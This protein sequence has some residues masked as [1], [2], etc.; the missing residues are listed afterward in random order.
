MGS[1]YV[2]E[3]LI[4]QDPQSAEIILNDSIQCTI[5]EG[6]RHSHNVLGE[7]YPKSDLHL[8]NIVD[9]ESVE[10]ISVPEPDI[11]IIIKHSDPEVNELLPIS[12]DV[13]SWYRS[14]SFSIGDECSSGAAPV[15][16]SMEILHREVDS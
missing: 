15:V 13:C 9:P 10:R 7:R 12:W 3:T 16:V 4:V 6:V 11:L 8:R 2:L 14:K 5:I 1:L